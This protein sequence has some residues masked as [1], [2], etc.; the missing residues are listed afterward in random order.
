[1]SSACIRCDG[2]IRGL[3]L[4]GMQVVRD[5]ETINYQLTDRPG[6]PQNLR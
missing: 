5:P 4:P 2:Q 1:M 6:V 3:H